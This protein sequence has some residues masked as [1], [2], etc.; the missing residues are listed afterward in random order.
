MKKLV[1]T[2][3]FFAL[4]FAMNYITRDL[5]GMG[6]VAGGIIALIA[7][8]VVL[9]SIAA[10]PG[11]LFKRGKFVPEH[12]KELLKGCRASTTENLCITSLGGPV[13]PKGLF[14]MG[15]VNAFQ[16][17]VPE[18]IKKFDECT[19]KI[20]EGIR[21]FDPALLPAVSAIRQRRSSLM[22]L[23]KKVCIDDVTRSRGPRSREIVKR[24]LA[25]RERKWEMLSDEEAMRRLTVFKETVAA[26]DNSCEHLL[27]DYIARQGQTGRS[28]AALDDSRQQ[29]PVDQAPQDLPSIVEKNDTVTP[30]TIGPDGSDPIRGEPP[31]GKPD[32]GELD[33]VDLNDPVLDRLRECIRRQAVIRK[34][35]APFIY[36]GAFTVTAVVWMAL[37]YLFMWRWWVCTLVGLMCGF[38]PCGMLLQLHERPVKKFF[39]EHIPFESPLELAGFEVFNEFTKDPEK[40]ICKAV[41]R[42]L[43]KDRGIRL[44]TTKT[45]KAVR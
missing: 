22:D 45:T 14:E 37:W 34:K 31:T 27:Q 41:A 42:Q 28:K 21:A 15:T 7:S 36:I 13:T 10:I 29:I 2:I 30:E 3:V 33:S 6:Q 11:A 12:L 1:V 44:Q 35:E 39:D 32:E 23:A 19:S 20:E 26:F 18:M 17:F 24:I 25:E 5:F 16:L 8:I 43:T 40:E 38:S 9:A 4:L